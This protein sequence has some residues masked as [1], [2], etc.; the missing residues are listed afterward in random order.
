MSTDDDKI[1]ALV[2]RTIAETKDMARTFAASNLLPPEYRG[3]EPNV[4]VAIVAGGELGLAPMAAIRLVNVINGKSI[5]SAD[6]MVGVVL[7]SG[8]AEYFIP[9]SQDTASVTWETKRRG[10]PQPT[11]ATWTLDDAKRAGLDGSNW[12]K[13]PRAMLNARCKAELARLVY[14]DVL[15][16]CYELSEGEEIERSGRVVE[17]QRRGKHDDVQDAEIV[18]TETV[19]PAAPKEPT[20]EMEVSDDWALDLIGRIEEAATVE[21]LKLLAP[22]I[23]KMPRGSAARR[24]CKATYDKRLTKLTTP[25]P[26]EQPA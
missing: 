9:I 7:G 12:K 13:Y 22:K 11:R 16:G 26:S 23:N 20:V 6:G 3:K 24:S 21:E 19:P 14:P 17:S 5:L 25:T 18:S 8:L 1:T 15:A 4:F 2:P 10:A